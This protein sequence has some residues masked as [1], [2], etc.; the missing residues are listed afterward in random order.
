MGRSLAVA[1]FPNVMRPLS[2]TLRPLKLRLKECSSGWD[3][4]GERPSCRPMLAVEGLECAEAVMEGGDLD[5]E[6]SWSS[7]SLMRFSR[8]WVYESVG[9][10]A[11]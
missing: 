11:G 8:R 6:A 1:P 9:L 7:S 10:L 5:A 2:S 3:F 4:G